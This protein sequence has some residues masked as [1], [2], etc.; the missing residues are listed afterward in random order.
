VEVV[1]SQCSIVWDT[2]QLR[3]RLSAPSGLARHRGRDPSK[4]VV[5]EE[6]LPVLAAGTYRSNRD[7][8]TQA[9]AIGHHIHHPYELYEKA[10][11]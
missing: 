3:A 1:L 11:L 2:W 7:A 5:Y 8:D 10:A 6:F 9:G 4:P